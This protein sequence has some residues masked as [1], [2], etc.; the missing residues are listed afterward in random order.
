MARLSPLLLIDSGLVGLFAFAALH[1]AFQWWLSRKERVLLV[2]AIHCAACALFSCVAVARHL[3]TTTSAMQV[4][5]DWSVTIGVFIHALV[6]LFYAVLAKRR[7][8]MF[9]AV[10][11]G[12]LVVLAVLNLWAPL[13]GT[14]VELRA[15]QLP[16]GG[17]SLVPI[18]TPPGVPLALMYVAM[19]AAKAYGCLIVVETWRSDRAGALLLAVGTLAST[20][21]VVI[22][23][24]IDYAHLR[25]PYVGAF[26]N[27]LFAL[28][29]AQLLSREYAAR[30]AR[31]ARANQD[32]ERVVV[33]LQAHRDKLEETVA[34]RTHELQVAKD[35]AD[36]A[37]AAKSQFLAHMSHEVRTPLSAIML[38]AQIL[39]R[40]ESLTETQR[41][42]IDIMFSSGKHLSTLLDEVLAMSRIEA[43]RVELV[44]AEFD[45]GKAL[46]DVQQ[47]FTVQCEAKGI[48]LTVQ[49]AAAL[50]V[51]LL[52]DAGKLKQILIN[53][54]SNAVKFTTKGSICVA[55]S[56]TPLAGDAIAL[57]FLVSDSGAGMAAV[58]LARVFH[59][60]E[61][62]TPTA[63]TSGTGLGLAI[64]LAYARL[65]HGD[66]TVQSTPGMGTTFTLTCTAKR[67]AARES[68]IAPAVSPSIPKA[69]P[70]C[71]V[72]VIDD[73]DINRNILVQLLQPP[74]FETRTAA[75]GPSALAI[76]ASWDP[77]LVLVD[78]RMEE[79][80][81]HEAVRRMRAT[82]SK[83]AIGVLTASAI[84]DDER[85][86]LT[87]GADFFLRRPY[88]ARELL[89]RIV[90]ALSRRATA[91]NILEP[92]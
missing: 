17:T 5:L 39:Q 92:S 63:R 23:V 16:G 30:A 25:A 67:S 35:V 49:R 22:G 75:D 64:S 81:G 52:G 55:A 58:D 3:A 80:D 70:N 15:I 13:R 69:L 48:T 10:V 66:L 56:A 89:E 31:V 33:E 73:E 45:L 21:G 62:L 90:A 65:M 54:V 2:F 42:T 88:D 59:P 44:E 46:E 32:Y 87:N 41:K 34:V 68:S 71:R 6:L 61:Q 43:G 7:D 86:A 91:S 8:V 40:D 83:A 26:P 79:M 77:H 57:E 84:A 82:G 76:Q 20:T 4:R 27:A 74:H 1:Y 19:F 47:M 14:V 18:R 36:R 9:C 12:V 24:L 11:F 28:C 85:I 78:L 38:Y 51:T 72:L 60:F 29:M 53:L 37:N 50:P